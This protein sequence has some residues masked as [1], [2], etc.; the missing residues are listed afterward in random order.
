MNDDECTPQEQ[1]S[2]LSVCKTCENFEFNP[3][4]TTKCAACDCSIS[5]LITFKDQAC[6]EGKW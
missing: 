5:L 6:P 4:S 1:E 3:D 2:R